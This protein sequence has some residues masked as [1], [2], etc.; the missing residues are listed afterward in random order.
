MRRSGNTKC[1]RRE[2]HTGFWYEN[3]QDGGDNLK[4]VHI[5]GRLILNRISVKYGRTVKD[6]FMSARI[7]PFG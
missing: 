6:T 7:G 3:T 1:M 2:I 5:G 4:N